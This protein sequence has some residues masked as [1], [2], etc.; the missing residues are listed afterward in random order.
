VI[1]DLLRDGPV[2]VNLGL[3]DFAETIAAQD[4]PVV[5]VEWSPPPELDADLAA[6]LEELG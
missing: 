2:I 5:H 6:L 4:A 1:D 3:R